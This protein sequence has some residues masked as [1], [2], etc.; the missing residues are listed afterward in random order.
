MTAHNKN[1]PASYRVT[2][3]I[4]TVLS[5]MALGLFK[6]THSGAAMLGLATAVGLV[7]GAV[8]GNHIEGRHQRH[9]T[10]TVTRCHT[11]TRYETRTVGY[12]VTYRYR[13]RHHTTRM[14][15]DP[16]RF[17]RIGGGHGHWENGWR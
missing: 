11:Q 17:V 12:D 6:V 2:Q 5:D 10:E 7:G 16:G 13:G 9:G 8:L 15:H 1:I 14:D 3:L 4:R